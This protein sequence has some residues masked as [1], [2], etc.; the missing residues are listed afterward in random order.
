M[1][2]GNHDKYIQ[3]STYTEVEFYKGSPR[4]H[5]AILDYWR[6]DNQDATHSTLHY[7]AADAGDAIHAWGSTSWEDHFW[8]EAS[9]LRL[10][11]VY[12]GY[13]INSTRLKQAVGIGN[14]LIYINATNLLTFTRLIK[15]FDPELN[16]FGAGRY[17]LLS[18][19]NI[20]V[21]F[22]F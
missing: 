10:K 14:L 21:K 16:N 3:L 18:R 1:F 2:Q 8:R 17:P 22:A 4:V 20:G 13:N 7:N 19:Y 5:D 15:E 6:P 11:E 9:Y 12:A